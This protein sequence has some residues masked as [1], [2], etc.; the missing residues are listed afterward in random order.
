MNDFAPWAAAV[1]LLM[2]F[3]TDGGASVERDVE[4]RRDFY[5][6]DHNI[7]YADQHTWRSNIDQRLNDQ[8]DDMIDLR[9]SQNYQWLALAL[10]AVMFLFTVTI[11]IGIVVRQV[12][13]LSVQMELRFDRIERR[14]GGP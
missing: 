4:A 12:D 9:R 2:A 10:I 14:V 13:L 7:I 8:R 3:R 11:S 5:G 1:I 6:R